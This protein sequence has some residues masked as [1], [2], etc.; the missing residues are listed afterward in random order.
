MPGKSSHSASL[1]ALVTGIA[2]VMTLARCDSRSRAPRSGSNAPTN[3]VSLSE[4]EIASLKTE[5]LD[6]GGKKR[7]VF[8]ASIAPE[9]LSPWE[10][11]GNRSSGR[12][13]FRATASLDEYVLRR[14]GWMP[15]R[16][17][18]G[19]ACISVQNKDGTIVYFNAMEL[20]KLCPT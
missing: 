12:I 10:A 16:K 2:I 20:D 6:P 18:D 9:P 4:Q 8:E 11:Q 1:F 7:W 13:P 14:S 15:L 3:V 5:W 19:L 17:I